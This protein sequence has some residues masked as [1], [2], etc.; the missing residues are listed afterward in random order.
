MKYTIH[1]TK[2]DMV[3]VEANSIEDAFSKIQY[4]GKK[5]QHFNYATDEK[6]NTYRQD[7]IT[8]EIMS[9]KQY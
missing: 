7:P 5:I 8:Q 4:G 1:I 9:H 3:E 2:N 6:G